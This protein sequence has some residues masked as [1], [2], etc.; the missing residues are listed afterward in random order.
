MSAQPMLSLGDDADHFTPMRAEDVDAVM[1]IEHAVYPFPWTRGNFIDG[2]RAGY[3]SWL[4]RA[5][6]RGKRGSLIAYSLVMVAVDEAHLLNL[7]V[8]AGHQRAGAGWRMLEWMAQQAR[9]HGARGMFL[10]VRP[11]NLPA[12]RLYE[13]YGFR[14]V[15]CRRGYYPAHEGRE[16]A[17]VMRIAL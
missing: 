3:C 8:D 4:L 14:N 16:D 15:G 2:L 13:R 11:S 10:E 5:G 9:E 1:A 7:S 12:L 17:I 6:P